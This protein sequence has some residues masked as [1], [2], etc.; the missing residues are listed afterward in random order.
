MSYPAK[1]AIYALKRLYPAVVDLYVPGT[2]TLDLESG[3]QN[4]PATKYTIRKAII[5]PTVGIREGRYNRAYI[6][7]AVQFTVGAFTDT[8]T[9]VFIIDLKDIPSD[10]AVDCNCWIIYQ[11]ERYNIKIMNRHESNAAVE[12]FAVR[13]RGAPTNEQHDVA[14]EHSAGFTGEGD[15]T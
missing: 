9:R 7:S 1:R 4:Q 12:L 3:I 10:T 11:H 8:D 6:R 2:P 13:L 14:I 5:L 15:A